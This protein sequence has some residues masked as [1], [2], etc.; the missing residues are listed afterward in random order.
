MHKNNHP[1]KIENDISII[2]NL[3]QFNKKAEAGSF[4]MFAGGLFVLILIFGS[5]IAYSMAAFFGQGYDSRQIEAIALNNQLRLC[6]KQNN[7]DLSLPQDTLKNEIISK[8]SLNNQLDNKGFLIMFLL[9]KNQILKIGSGD[10]VL[11]A[12]SDKNQNLPRCANS[13]IETSRGSL[14]IWTGSNQ[15]GRKA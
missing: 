3:H 12:L 13:T 9:N 1:H 7:I 4:V 15:Q 6:I 11:C 14:T 8:C 5:V 2:T 10:N